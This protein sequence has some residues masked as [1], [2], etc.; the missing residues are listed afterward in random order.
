MN[1]TLHAGFGHNEHTTILKRPTVVFDYYYPYICSYYYIISY[2]NNLIF[3]LSF[4]F[5]KLESSNEL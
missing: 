1:G 2:L 4:Y 5:V 3:K